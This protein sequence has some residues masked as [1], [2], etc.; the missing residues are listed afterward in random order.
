MYIAIEQGILQDTSLRQGV[1]ILFRAIPI[2][3]TNFVTSIQDYLATS[4]PPATVDFYGMSQDVLLMSWPLTSVKQTQQR[5][6]MQILILLSF[7]LFF[8]L[9]WVDWREK[10]RQ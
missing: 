7:F 9:S 2:H 8:F 3:D 1:L 5:W 4:W 6:D 10:D